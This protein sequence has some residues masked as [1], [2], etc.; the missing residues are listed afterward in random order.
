M[1]KKIR[2]EASGIRE[3]LRTLG[4]GFRRVLGGAMVAAMMGAAGYCFAKVTSF[5]G[6]VA[7]AV[8]TGG[9]AFLIE[10]L[11]QMW[12]M[13]GGKKRTGAFDK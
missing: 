10:A 8:F 7:V 13:G 3:G 2:F 11:W 9:A 5:G 1:N 12:V 6:Y 4:K